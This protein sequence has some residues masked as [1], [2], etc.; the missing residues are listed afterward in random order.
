MITLASRKRDNSPCRLLV[1]LSAI[2]LSLSV[3]PETLAAIAIDNTS[4]T[5]ATAPAGNT[6]SWSHTVGS[7]NYRLLIVGVSLRRSGSTE[8]ASSVTFGGTSLTFKDRGQSTDK[9]EKYVSEIWYLVAP[10]V[11]TA[12]VQVTFSG[13]VDS[14]VCAAA[15]FTRVDPS[16][17][18]GT[19]AKAGGTAGTPSVTVSSAAGELVIDTISIRG[20][21]TSITPGGGRRSAGTTN[22]APAAPTPSGAEAPKPER[23]R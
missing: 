3:V 6:I 16:T 22:P 1:S 5:H 13:A 17:P 19:S 11:G 7:G 12:T 10:A 15:S 21:A 20:T 4:H 23:R 2:I 9:N 14:T 8:T 18:L